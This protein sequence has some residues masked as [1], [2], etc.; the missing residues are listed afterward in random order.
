MVG[1]SVG[2]TYALL[3]LVLLTACVLWLVRFQFGLIHLKLVLV[4][5]IEPLDWKLACCSTPCPRLVESTATIGCHHWPPVQD[6][7]WNEECA[8][9]LQISLDHV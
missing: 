8:L 4:Y 9:K 7:L 1:L 3:K 6:L 5:C 2:V